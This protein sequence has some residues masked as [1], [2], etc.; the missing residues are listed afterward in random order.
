MD[1]VG[2]HNDASKY[3]PVDGSRFMLAIGGFGIAA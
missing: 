1:V 2:Y 3:L